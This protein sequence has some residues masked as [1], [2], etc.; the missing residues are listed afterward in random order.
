MICKNMSSY[1]VAYLFTCLMV[2]LAEQK[3]LILMKSNL[4]LCSFMNSDLATVSKE[5]LCN[6]RSERFF[7]M[8]FVYKFYGFVFYICVYNAV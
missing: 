1:T 2:S 3:F 4:S 7:P 6:S 5:S 8:F